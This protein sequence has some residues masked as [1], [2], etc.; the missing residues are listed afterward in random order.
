MLIA[1]CHRDKLALVRDIRQHI[2]RNLIL[3]HF[4]CA[5]RMNDDD[6]LLLTGISRETEGSLELID[7]IGA[8]IA[9][10]ILDIVAVS[11]ITDFL[12]VDIQV[13]AAADMNR[14]RLLCLEGC[15]NRNI[16]RHQRAGEVSGYIVFALLVAADRPRDGFALLSGD[17]AHI[18]CQMIVVL[19]GC[20]KG[21][22]G[23]KLKS[24]LAVDDRELGGCIVHDTEIDRIHFLEERDAFGGAD[25]SENRGDFLLFLGFGD[26]RLELDVAA[27]AE[28]AASAASAAAPAA[29][30]A[31]APAAASSAAAS[32]ILNDCRNRLL[33]EGQLDLEAEGVGVRGIV[34]INTGF[35]HLLQRHSVDSQAARNQFA[36]VDNDLLLLCFADFIDLDLCLAREIALLVDR[37]LIGTERLGDQNLTLGIRLQGAFGHSAAL[38]GLQIDISEFKRCVV[39]IDGCQLNRAVLCRI[40]NCDDCRIASGVAGCVS[41]C[42]EYGVSAC[43]FKGMKYSGTDCGRIIAEF[44]VVFSDA[45]VIG[46]IG[47]VK[48]YLG[49]GQNLHG[50]RQIDCRC[51]DILVKRKAVDLL[52]LRMVA[53]L[54]IDRNVVGV[55]CARYNIFVSILLSI[56]IVPV[57]PCE[58]R[59]LFGLA[60]QLVAVEIVILF[61][62]PGKL[63]LP[64]ILCDLKN[65]CI[66]CGCHQRDLCKGRIGRLADIAAHIGC[67]CLH[68][69][70]AVC[71]IRSIPL[72]GC[73]LIV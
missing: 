20:C 67:N 70:D 27:V 14:E 29:G 57:D 33:R 56:G 44:P 54:V 46:R 72:E 55:D 18:L 28:R 43:L 69:V 15:I 71:Q 53:E 62:C 41:C 52:A 58:F 34:E 47:T 42:Q 59:F 6:L 50:F 11:D 4:F 68:A 65:R 25:V 7:R 2:A 13:Q 9:E 23:R 60:E 73:R 16:E 38:I 63:D 32:D 49:A 10:C 31:A 37:N 21:K 40:K 35:D 48:E 66:R 39:L 64:V 8:L 5:V 24:C 30:P 36:A 22:T 17:V 12:G 45:D 19:G 3:L 26:N 1:V 51:D 61:G